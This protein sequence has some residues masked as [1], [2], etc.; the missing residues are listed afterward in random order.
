MKLKEEYIG[1]IIH[2]PKTNKVINVDDIDNAEYK[3]YYD[4]GY[5]HLFD[6]VSIE[7]TTVEP[8]KIEEALPPVTEEPKEE[9]TND[10]PN[11]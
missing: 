1:C 2:Q 9:S 10:I 5:Q 6:E 11:Q 4:N 3:Y 8:P 7:E